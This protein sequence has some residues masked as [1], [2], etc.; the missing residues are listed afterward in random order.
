MIIKI[1]TN[2]Y[3]LHPKV[4][5]SINYLLMKK[6]QTSKDKIL[7]DLYKENKIIPQKLECGDYMFNNVLVEHKAL[8]DFCNSVTNGLI[9]QQ[10]QDMLYFKE[11][12][13]DI[14]LFILISGNPEDIIK[15]PHAPNIASMI[16]AWSSLNMRIP[17]SFMG[18]SYWF[19]NGLVDLF[20]KLFDGKVREYSPIRRPQEFDDIILSNYVSIVGEKTAKNLLKKFP[21][22]K[23]LYNSTKEQLM[24]VDL[25]G[26]ETA[27]FIVNFS[28]GKEKSWKIS[29]ERKKLSKIK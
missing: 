4:V 19:V 8:Q 2:E 20:E 16:A 11:Q 22:P 14:K 5:E 21:I 9:F 23:Q 26:K 15:L 18:N 6:Q 27:E 25:V 10:C 12:N 7:I 29:E 28:E 1:D 3:A 13:P 24:E 17:T